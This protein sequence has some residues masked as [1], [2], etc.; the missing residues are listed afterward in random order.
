M[1]KEKTWIAALATTLLI[2]A[3]GGTDAGGDGDASGGSGNSGKPM[4]RGAACTAAE[5]GGPLDW[6]TQDP[7]TAETIIGMFNEKYPDIEVNFTQLLENDIAQRIVAE[8]NAKKVTADLAV[9][10]MA[11]FQPLIERNLVDT[12][13]QWP[14]DISDNL[15]SDSNMIRVSR[16]ANGIVYNTEQYSAEDLPDTWEDL[17]DP[18]WAGKTSV[19]TTGIPFDV[20][21]IAWGEEKTLDW[22]QRLAET[23]Q[24]EVINGTTAGIQAAASGEVP[25]A[26]SGRD[27]EANE[28][29]AAG[30]PVDIKYLDPVPTFD[31]YEMIPAGAEDV[32]AAVC[33]A[34]W[35]VTDA[36]DDVLALSY[37]TNDD[38]PP[39]LPAGAE[40]ISVTPDDVAQLGKMAPEIS[41]IWVNGG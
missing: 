7:E 38:V 21:S 14:T 41:D 2:S 30:A 28:Q 22:A 26:L 32:D 5:S 25:I 9:G 39:G 11:A 10:H 23:V 1:H 4:D 35:Y 8:S 19:H 13:L 18:K 3:C 36:K 16:R 20:L 12:E 37:T 6:W 34:T 17:V 40:V 27:S 24:P 31:F 15:K 33:F 29:K